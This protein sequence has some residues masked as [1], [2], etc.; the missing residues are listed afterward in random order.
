MRSKLS[1]E[2]ETALRLILALPSTTDTNVVPDEVRQK[3]E[4]F[5]ADLKANEFE[6]VD[7]SRGVLGLSIIPARGPADPS[8]FLDAL[9]Q[10]RVE[11]QPFRS[12]AWNHGLRGRFFRTFTTNDANDASATEVDISGAVRAATNR[13]FTA[14]PSG[15]GQAVL[16]GVISSMPVERA[17]RYLNALQQAGLRGSCWLT[18]AVVSLPQSRLQSGPFWA[19]NSQVCEGDI[20]PDPVRVEIGN[21]ALTFGEVAQAMRPALDQLWREFEQMNCPLFDGSGKWLKAGAEP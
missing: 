6:G 7:T 11:M 1:A 18:V 17:T 8:A 3:T 9:T 20:T 12:S 19:G 2:V 21:E 4:S 14:A 15:Q 16:W 5:H 10:S 13:I